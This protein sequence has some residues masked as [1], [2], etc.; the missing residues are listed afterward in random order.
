MKFSTKQLFI[1]SAILAILT[2]PLPFVW[3]EIGPLGKQFY[4]ANVP[5]IYILGAT[6]LG[7]DRSFSGI[8]FAFKFQ[9]I[10]IIY[11]SL[12]SLVTIKILK[13]RKATLRLSNIN[14]FLLIL[15]PEWLYLYTGGVL[16]NSDGAA[17]DIEIHVGIGLLLYVV[18]LFIS[19]VIMKRLKNE[20]S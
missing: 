20:S 18:L 10:I 2:L 11:F 3:L 1:I 15:F 12:S 16:N 17:S 19:I 6:I 13:N 8:N 5:D 4:G 7:K 14:L 9:L